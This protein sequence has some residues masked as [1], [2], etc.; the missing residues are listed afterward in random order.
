MKEFDIYGWVAFIAV[1]V[2]GINMGLFGI[3]N[4]NL[5]AAI[6]GNLLGRLLFIGIGVGAGYLGYLLYLEK[7][8]KI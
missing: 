6:F 5:I 8:K 2:G 3:I 4:V 1:L 7:F